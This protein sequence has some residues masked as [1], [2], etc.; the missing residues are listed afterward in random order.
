MKKLVLMILALAMIVSMAGCGC[1]HTAGDMQLIE[2]NTTELELKWEIPCTACGKVMET[3]TT[4]PGI[5]PVNSVL[6][7]SPEE[8]FGCLT[9]ILRTYDTTGTLMP[10][11][12][13][14]QDGALLYSV[15]TLSGFKSVISF[16]DSEGNVLTTDQATERNKI[17]RI[18]VE[19]QFD[20]TMTESFYTLLLLMGMNNND[21]WTSEGINLLGKQIMGGETVSD[22]GYTY[23]LQILSAEDHTVAVSITAE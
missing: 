5:A 3:K 18:L 6:A 9:T 16:Y 2:V 1:D 22:N 11:T 23:G 21:Q 17:N 13:E 4:A 8:W 15:L 20:N 10:T 7:M 12:A 14:S 19:A